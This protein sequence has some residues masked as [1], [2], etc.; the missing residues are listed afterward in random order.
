MS[1]TDWNLNERGTL[2]W[3]FLRVQFE[4]KFEENNN[5]HLYC[6]HIHCTP[7]LQQLHWLPVRQRVVF[8]IAVLVFQ[9]LAGQMVK[10]WRI[11]I[12]SPL[13]RFQTLVYLVYHISV[14]LW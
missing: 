4:H 2:T 6:K 5:N 9:C 3:L 11:I 13:P 7:I 14:Y 12:K 1:I 8:E 10:I